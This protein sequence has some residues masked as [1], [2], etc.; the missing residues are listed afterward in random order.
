MTRALWRG[1]AVCE[2]MSNG[3][4]A[5]TSAFC[6]RTREEA[7][8]AFSRSLGPDRYEHGRRKGFLS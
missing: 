6:G 3:Q 5:S 4:Y 7:I 8:A 1:W 2:R